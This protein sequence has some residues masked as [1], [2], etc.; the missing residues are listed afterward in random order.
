MRRLWPA[1][2]EWGIFLPNATLVRVDFLIGLFRFEGERE[3]SLLDLHKVARWTRVQDLWPCRWTKLA[4]RESTQE[5]V[6]SEPY[7]SRWVGRLTAKAKGI[8]VR[9]LDPQK[10]CLDER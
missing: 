10:W 4:G 7:N 1:G 9:Q 8:C 2:F 3:H 6:V 5:R